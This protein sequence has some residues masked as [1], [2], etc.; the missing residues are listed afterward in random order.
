MDQVSNLDGFNLVEVS[1]NVWSFEVI[2]GM[3]YMGNLAHVV[4]IAV[5]RY[6]ISISEIE[7][8]V[9]DMIKNGYTIA[10]FGMWRTYMYGYKPT[11]GKR[12][13]S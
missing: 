8:A 2:G 12:L 10:H 11:P 4:R 9:E 1:N 13:V 5:K 7:V 6:D 3:H